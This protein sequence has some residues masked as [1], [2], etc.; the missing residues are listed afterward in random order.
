MDGSALLSGG[1]YAFLETL[2]DGW[3]GA[4]RAAKSRG[5]PPN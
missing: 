3:E 4:S 5:K 2:T 1:G